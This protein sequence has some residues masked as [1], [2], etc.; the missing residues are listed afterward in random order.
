MLVYHNQ[1]PKQRTCSRRTLACY[2][3]HD[4]QELVA[5]AAANELRRTIAREGRKAAKIPSFTQQDVSG[6]SWLLATIPLRS[7]KERPRPFHRGEA[8]IKLQNVNK[9]ALDYWR[10]MKCGEDTLFRMS[11]HLQ[12]NRDIDSPMTCARV[13]RFAAD[14]PRAKDC[15]PPRNSIPS[16]RYHV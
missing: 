11:E 10:P 1:H 2:C 8:T 7:F 4:D 9:T 3:T 13:A 15:R 16:R 5:G 6:S 12:T 14:E